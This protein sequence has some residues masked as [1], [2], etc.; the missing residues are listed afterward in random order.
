MLLS[1]LTTL[2]A[3]VQQHFLVTT[4]EGLTLLSLKITTAHPCYNKGGLFRD[5]SVLYD[6]QFWLYSCRYCKMINRFAGRGFNNHSPPWVSP[7]LYFFDLYC[8]NY[9]L[10]EFFSNLIA[11]LLVLPTWPEICCLSCSSLFCCSFQQCAAISRL[12]LNPTHVS[13][14]LTP[15]WHHRCFLFSLQQL[16]VTATVGP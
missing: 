13:C 11:L 2:T 6:D 10:L 15:W 7:Q 4:L 3:R 5:L 16:S 8:W 12:I 14:C 1:D 9:F